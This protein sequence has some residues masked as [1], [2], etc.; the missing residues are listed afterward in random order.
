MLFNSYIFVLLFLPLV[1]AGYYLCG[2]WKK[3][4]WGK[5]W[6]IGASLWF[7][8]Y[9]N[10][11]YLW[12]ITVSVIGNYL[13]YGLLRKWQAA[14]KRQVSLLYLTVFGACVNLGALF[15]YKYYDFFIENVNAAFRLDFPLQHVLLPLGISFFTFQ[16]VGFLV[17]AYRK[18][19][20]E[21]RFLDYAAFVLFFPQLVAGPIVTHEEMIPQFQD[22][23]K[24]SWNS[25]NFAKG[26][27]AFVHGLAK[28]VLIADVFG[29]AVSWGYENLETLNG[30]GAVLLMIS[31]MVQLYFDFSGYSDMARGLGFMFNIEIP[32]NFNSPYKAVN[33]VD[34]WKRWHITLNRFFTR[35]VY[36]PL[37]GNRK[38]VARTYFNIFMVYLV[39]GIWHGAGW[40]YMIWGTLHGVVYAF[41][42]RFQ[43]I[44]EKVPKAVGWVAN[45]L[46]F[47]LSL[48]YFRSESIEQAHLI[49]EKMFRGGYVFSGIP[50]EFAAQF[51]TKEFFYLLKALRF[52]GL[53]FFE[54][55]LMAGYMIGAW[56]ILL[57]CRNVNE[58]I[59][60]F[61]PT[62]VNA[63][64]TA[65]LFLWS[66]ISF[67]QVSIFLYFNF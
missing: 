31:Y 11:S 27:Y 41:T 17:D 32:I 16:Q 42:R 58:K 57:V 49:F 47:L 2:R 43:N 22:V 35:Y 29:Q 18:E 53:A 52:D 6:L 15:Y 5:I 63:V 62:L 64:A 24:K 14:K 56:F 12:I 34:F 28:K 23:T 67:S 36:I 46:F 59:A 40:T 1:I 7:Y 37:G 54:Y 20:G 9:F 3:Y 25:E 8:G 38:G 65:V 51:S 44:V 4:E 60:D 55:Y 10:P 48:V 19:T 21:Y 50:A 61:K 13:L 45:S 66:L 33:L 26:M 30:A 39:S